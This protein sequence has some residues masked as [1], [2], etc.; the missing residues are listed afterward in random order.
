[1]VFCLKWLV[2]PIHHI[3]Q[4]ENL[5]GGRPPAAWSLTLLLQ[6]HGFGVGAGIPISYTYTSWHF[7]RPPALPP[8]GRD[9]EG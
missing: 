6:Q 5:D 1:M 8:V 9:N 2:P 4:K 3:A 7:S